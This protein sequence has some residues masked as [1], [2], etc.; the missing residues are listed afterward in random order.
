MSPQPARVQVIAP[1]RI[2]ETALAALRV[3]GID[4]RIATGPDDVADDAL[5]WALEG[6]PTGGA[7]LELAATCARA[8]AAGRPVCLLAPVPRG[9]GRAA[10]ERAAALAYVRAHGAALAHDVDAWLEAIV[11]LV[12]LGV[13]RGPRSAVIAP[14]GSWLEAQ[15]QALIAEAEAAGARPIV[16]GRGKADEPT[17]AVLFD[18]ALGPP[19]GQLAGLA[20][21]VIAR[22]ELAEGAIALYGAR[23]ALAAIDVLGR[24]AER[25]AIGLGPAPRDAAAELEIDRER[26]ARQ[27]AKLPG[28]MRVG[29]HETKIL[30]AAYGVPI[31][32]QAV[33]VTPSAAVKKARLVKYPVELKPWGHD[34]PTEPAGC[35]I[36]RGVTSDALVRRAFAAVLAAAGRLPSKTEAG[37]VIVREAPPLGRDVAAS[38]VK[39]PALG[40]TVVLDAPG[41]IAAAPAPLRL[42]DAQALAAAFASTRAGDAEPDRAGLANVLRRASHLAVDLGDRLRALE[43]P[44]VVVGGRGARSLVV[45]AWCELA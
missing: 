4:A 1:A 27:L 23:A 20:V 10:I 6:S 7:A 36:E 26:L 25:A 30:L 11:A 24:A 12:K 2:G 13:P 35:P 15:T 28:A 39:L 9:S 33:A 31:T 41:G 29:D 34:L 43:L 45:D 17:D 37:A 22:G 18:P 14:P 16:L 38:I 8:A 44:R 21:P 42:I 19:P 5:A 32:R 40:W 3:R